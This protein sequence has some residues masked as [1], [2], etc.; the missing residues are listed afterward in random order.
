MLAH[1]V[2]FPCSDIPICIS[3]N[4]S[5][6]VLSGGGRTR[7]CDLEGMNLASFLLLHPAIRRAA[8]HPV[9]HSPEK[10]KIISERSST[11]VAD[12]ERQDLNLRNLTVW[13]FHTHLRGILATPPSRSGQLSY[14]PIMDAT[15]FP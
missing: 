5:F 13:R 6:R 8:Y 15:C 10:E 4:M 1:R 14:V 11:P 7:T 12:L 2:W 3:L 9:F